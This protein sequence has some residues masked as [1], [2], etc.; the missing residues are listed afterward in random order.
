MS[1]PNESAST[2]LSAEKPVAQGEPPQILEHRLPK[3]GVRWVLMVGML[4][5]VVASALCAAASVFLARSFFSR[6]GAARDVAPF[7]GALSGAIATVIAIRSVIWFAGGRALRRLGAGLGSSA[8]EGAKRDLPQIWSSI[9]P[10]LDASFSHYGAAVLVG[11]GPSSAVASA[12]ATI[13]RLGGCNCLVRVASAGEPAE[14]LP[15]PFAHPFEPTPL[16]GSEKSFIEWRGRPVTWADHWADFKKAMDS[17]SGGKRWWIYLVRAG[18]LFALCGVCYQS[19]A[20]IRQLLLGNLF[21][22]LW[23][24]AAVSVGIFAAVVAASAQMPSWAIVPS[25]VIAR[26]RNGLF[27]ASRM[28]FFDRR[29]SACIV[30]PKPNRFIAVASEDGER[31]T[32]IVTGPELEGFLRAWL[33]PLPPPTRAQIDS[34]LGVGV[35]LPEAKTGRGLW[36]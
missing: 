9:A 31:A 26:R 13:A 3:A 2:G 32:R 29:H 5:G 7:L 17:S 1:E 27:G 14:A 8:P 24:P 15:A 25:G 33:S 21:G 16:S 18:L 19:V 23:F 35:D 10:L 4:L 12:A 36:S 30:F 22:A 11:D 20:S 28:I 6:V 34:Y